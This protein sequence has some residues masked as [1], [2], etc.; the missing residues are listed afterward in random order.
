MQRLKAR[1]ERLEK[2]LT[3]VQNEPRRWVVVL[4]SG[5]SRENLTYREIDEIVWYPPRLEHRAT[6]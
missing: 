6:R 2:T 4:V 5:S 1:L 3:P